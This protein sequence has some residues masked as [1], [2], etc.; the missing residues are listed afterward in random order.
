MK[1]T[2]WEQTSTESKRKMRIRGKMNHHRIYHRVTYHL[3]LY[4][5]QTGEVA[6]QIV[7]TKLSDVLTN[8]S[9][10]ECREWLEL[11]KKNE[12]DVLG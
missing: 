9:P 7:A 1:L 4:K 8:M 3:E 5:R 10:E 11:M 2:H 12:I 6:K